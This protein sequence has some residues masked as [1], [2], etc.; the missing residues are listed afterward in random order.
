M[1]TWKCS[2]ILTFSIGPRLNN[3]KWT[4]LEEFSDLAM[5]GGMLGFLVVKEFGRRAPFFLGLDKLW[6]EIL[7]STSRRLLTNFDSW[8]P[9][10]KH[11]LAYYDVFSP[12]IST[13][14]LLLLDISLWAWPFYTHLLKLLRAFKRIGEAPNNIEYES[15]S[16][17]SIKLPKFIASASIQL[18]RAYPSF[19]WCRFP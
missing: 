4:F 10:F 6:V 16:T 12:P 3:M 5:F 17:P 14:I 15:L 2:E 8:S 7:S 9:C 18:N 13:M 19:T 11:S 1:C